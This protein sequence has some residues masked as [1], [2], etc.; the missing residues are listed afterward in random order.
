MAK[1][2][3][4]GPITPHGVNRDF[5]SPGLV[6]AE[7]IKNAPSNL[8]PDLMR[9]TPITGGRSDSDR[10]RIIRGFYSSLPEEKIITQDFTTEVAFTSTLNQKHQILS[11]SVPSDRSF[12][13]DS[14][15][16]FATQAF[17]VGLIPSGIIEGAVQCYFEIGKV[18]P[19][20][21]RVSRIQAGLLVEQRAYFPL[22]NED[23]G[24]TRTTFT[25]R[26]KSGREV[27]AYYINRVVAPIPVNT[28]GVRVRGWLIDS[29]IVEEILQQQQ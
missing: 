23:I 2:N 10:S 28:V 17:G 25:L 20:G 26:A 9:P 19:V 6:S 13:V 18:V 12:F 7:I 16:F 3:K 11:Y 8:D 24:Q 4:I 15:V 22:L 1:G 5:K 29:N 14:I 21:L 27:D